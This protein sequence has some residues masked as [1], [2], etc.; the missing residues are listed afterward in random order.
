M[1]HSISMFLGM[2]VLS[3]TL[4]A[5]PI[6]QGPYLGQTPPGITAKVFAPGLICQENRHESSGSFSADGKLFCFRIGSETY[7]A[8]ETSEGWTPP[9]RVSVISSGGFNSFLACEGKAIYFS[10]K[11]GRLHVCRRT[12][13]GWANPEPLPEPVNR[14]SGGFS[15]AADNSF[16]F[17]SWQPGG[18]GKCDLWTA[19]CVKG[20]WTAPT[21]IVGPNTEHCDCGPAISSDQRFMV[22][23]SNRPGGSGKLD[24]YASRRLDDGRWTEATN[25]GPNIN[26]PAT[27]VHATI[28][29][30][31]K[32]LFFSSRGDIYWVEVKAFLPALDGLGRITERESSH[33]Q[34]TP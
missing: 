26:S 12:A 13:A 6:A 11:D 2:V 5:A 1:K 30:D 28:S 18:H 4:L 3:G 17:C 34:K 23:W 7:V 8:E 32:Y 27:E 14:S 16:Y 15:L 19:P 22:L 31:N 25:L 9:E 24:L 20:V 21:N 10:N 33:E 29:P